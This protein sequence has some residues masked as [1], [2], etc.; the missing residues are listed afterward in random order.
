MYIEY[1]VYISV[2]AYRVYSVY[3]YSSM[4]SV[5]VYIVVEVVVAIVGV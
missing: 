1:I 5:H 2:Y 3:V 4:C